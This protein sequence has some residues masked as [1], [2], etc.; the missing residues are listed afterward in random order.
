MKDQN[1][2][3]K[4]FLWLIL[5]AVVTILLCYMFVVLYF[6]FISPNNISIKLKL[7]P[8]LSE[9]SIGEMYADST[10]EIK[11]SS[12]D[13]EQSEHSVIGVNVA[14]NGV[15]VAPYHKLK[16]LNERPMKIY[17][18]SGKVFDGELIFA[19]ES[20]DIAILKCKTTENQKISVPYAEIA[21]SFPKENS[22]ILFV[23]SP[24]GTNQVTKGQFESYSADFALQVEVQNFLAVDYVIENGG[25]MKVENSQLSDG[26]VFDLSGNLL[27][28]SYSGGIDLKGNYVVSS[29]LNANLFLK[30]VVKAYEKGEKFEKAFPNSL[31]GM[32]KQ[33]LSSHFDVSDEEN[34]MKNHFFFRN[35]WKDYASFEGLTNF[36]STPNSVGFFLLEDFEYDDEKILAGSI[37]TSVSIGGVTM[38]IENRNDLFEI[39]YSVQQ[40][41][42]CQIE[43]VSA[44][45]QTR[46]LNFVV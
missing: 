32:D 10:M 29:A 27:G 30:N 40:G 6:F 34:G 12:G 17:S 36:Y 5:L 41:Q 4:K 44:D 21:T 42:K 22:P 14:E 19:E 3:N 26:A 35:Q 11:F 28:F 9:E 18:N 38:H 16:R 2:S 25:A 46:T 24:L 39:A 23:S 15:V 31:V 20:F 1:Q 37:I 45:A 43:Y 13:F 8:F 33:E 7:W